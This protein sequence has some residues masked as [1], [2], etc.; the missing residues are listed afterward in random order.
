MDSKSLYITILFLLSLIQ[1]Q[2]QNGQTLKPLPP[3]GNSENGIS[4]S[5]SNL[6][7]HEFCGADF[8]HNLRMKNDV[9]YKARH[10]KTNQAQKEMSEQKKALANG[11]I[12]IPVVVHIMHRGDAVG[13]G[14]NISHADVKRGI[15]YLNNYWRKVTGTWGAGV[16]MKME[17]VLAVQHEN[18][19]PTNGI[20]QYDHP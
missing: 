14:T 19:N 10:L 4:Q 6:T 11:V 1:S 15:R 17:F 5:E 12:Q 7:N 13:T 16:D 20:D 8:I 9:Q 18:G 3:S 2:A